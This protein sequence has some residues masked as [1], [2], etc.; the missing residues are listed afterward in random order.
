MSEASKPTIRPLSF[1]ER[2]EPTCPECLEHMFTAPLLM[3]SIYS[4]GIEAAGG[5]AAV[6][7]SY[8]R[9]YHARQHPSEEELRGL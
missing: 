5:A 3:E 9:S 4:V 1:D 6:F 7:R 8:F 2:G